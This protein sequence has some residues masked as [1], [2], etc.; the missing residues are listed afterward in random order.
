VSAG[1]I[2]LQQIE[3]MSDFLDTLLAEVDDERFGLRPAP[4]RNPI[5]FIY[6]HLLR[7]WDLDLNVL[8]QGQPAAED[9]WHRGE[10]S[11]AM[12]YSPDG[13]GGRGAGLGFGYSDQ[14]VDEVPYRKDVLR[15]YHHQLLDETRAYLSAA[16]DD[17]LRREI[18]LR[19][20]S[21]TTGARMQHTAAHSWNHIGEIRLTKT[22]LGFQDPTT[23]S[24]QPAAVSS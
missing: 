22:M 21:T 3:T 15:R 24:R 4:E 5:G 1:A 20:Q 16:S 23:P 9:A 19:D 2:Y 12:G 14:E 13:K 11:E 7:V 6:F 18:M 10:Y 17:E 8:C